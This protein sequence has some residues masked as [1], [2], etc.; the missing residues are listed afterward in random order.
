[1]SRPA[2]LFHRGRL[3]GDGAHRRR[4]DPARRAR[5]S[6]A[7]PRPGGIFQ[8]GRRSALRPGPGFLGAAR[9]APIPALCPGEPV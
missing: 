4:V 9:S 1:G 8:P 3:C 7:N 6:G 2:R 5:S